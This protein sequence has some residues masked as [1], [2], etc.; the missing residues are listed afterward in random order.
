MTNLWHKYPFGWKFDG[1]RFLLSTYPTSDSRVLFHR[2]IRERIK[3]LAPF[4]KFDADAYVV[5]VDGK[6]YWIIDGYT[7]ST[8]YPYSESFSGTELIENKQPERERKST[9]GSTTSLAGAT[10]LRKSVTAAGD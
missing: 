8:Y 9:H 1:T 2:E 7:T 4:L 6:L 5:L 10:Y 3:T